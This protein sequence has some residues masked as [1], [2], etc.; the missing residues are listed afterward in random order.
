MIFWAMGPNVFDPNVDEDSD[1]VKKIHL[2][3]KHLN[4]QLTCWFANLNTH[5]LRSI[6]RLLQHL[7][8]FAELRLD[9]HQLLQEDGLQLAGPGSHSD[10]M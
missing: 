5:G 7:P 4:A 1:L 2:S 9:G 10:M 3:N 8:V 6:D